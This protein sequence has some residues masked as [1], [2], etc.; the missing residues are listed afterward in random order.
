MATIADQVLSNHCQK[1]PSAA[2]ANRAWVV[3]ALQVEKLG[4]LHLSCPEVV[5]P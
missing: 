3:Q 2:L 4:S 5:I 1:P